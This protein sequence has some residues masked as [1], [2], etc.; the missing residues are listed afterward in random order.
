MLWRA[1]KVP[2]H[3]AVKEKKKCVRPKAEKMVAGGKNGGYGEEKMIK[4]S[5]TQEDKAVCEINGSLTLC[6][7]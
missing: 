6:R 3:E 5:L 2:R 4:G 1:L 7:I